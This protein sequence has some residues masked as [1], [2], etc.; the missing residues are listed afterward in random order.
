MMFRTHITIG[1]LAG[2]LML[3]MLTPLNPVLF[4]FLALVGSAMPD[5]DHPESEIGR[6]VKIVAFLFEH[7]GFFHSLFATLLFYLLFIYYLGSL[8]YG[9]YVFAFVIGYFSHILSDSLTREGIMPFHP[10][11]K[12]RVHGFIRTGKGFEYVLLIVVF[13]LSMWRLFTLN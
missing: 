5:I 8:R 1:F 2:L 10:L 9:V 7:R 12:F 4:I 11:S 13:M 6:K 3:P